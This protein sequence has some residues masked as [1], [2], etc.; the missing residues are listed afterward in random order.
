MTL[1]YKEKF[2]LCSECYVCFSPFLY[3]FNNT[4]ILKGKKLLITVPPRHI[5][6]FLKNSLYMQIHLKNVAI[7]ILDYNFVPVSFVCRVRG[8]CVK[9]FRK[10]CIQIG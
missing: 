9:H 4:V 1:H 5:K 8:K 7:K 2:K 10:L 6:R 3:Y